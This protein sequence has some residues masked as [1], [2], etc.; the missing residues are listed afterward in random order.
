MPSGIY[1]LPDI[2]H[3]NC[4]NKL[5]WKLILYADNIALIY[6]EKNI[7]IMQAHMT[8]DMIKLQEWLDTQRPN[9]TLK[10]NKIYANK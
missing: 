6:N 4:R 1:S 10:K 3:W 9:L 5:T 8:E 2:Y 7:E